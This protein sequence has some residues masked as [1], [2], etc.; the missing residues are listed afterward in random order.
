MLLVG[1]LLLCHAAAFLGIPPENGRFFAA[2]E[3][4]AAGGQGVCK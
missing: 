4:R 1:C 2:G 3:L